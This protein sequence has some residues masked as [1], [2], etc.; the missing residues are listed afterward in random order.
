MSPMQI[1]PAPWRHLGETLAGRLTARAHG[2]FSPEFVLLDSEGARIGELEVQGPTGADLTAGD[3]GARIKRAERSGYA[4][5]SSG[6][7]IL[8][9]TADPTSPEITCFNRT[10]ASSLSLLRN[11]AEAGPKDGT[12]TVRIKGGLTNRTYE[13]SFDP[14]DENALPV[15]LF[16]LYRLISQRSRAYVAGG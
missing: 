3:V 6:G 1:D 8:T 4:M 11:K 12:T 9:S 15:A 16:L 7:E 2:L 10:Y 14:G 13:A 5:L